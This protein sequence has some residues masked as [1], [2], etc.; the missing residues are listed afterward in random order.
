MVWWG[1]L[2]R[3]VDVGHPGVVDVD[4]GGRGPQHQAAL[5]VQ[6]GHAVGAAAQPGVHGGHV[7]LP[8][9]LLLLALLLGVGGGGGGGG[10]LGVGGDR[11][12]LARRVGPG[13]DVGDALA[14]QLVDVE[15][16]HL[17]ALSR[18]EREREMCT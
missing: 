14:D 9:L 13:G 18:T 10:Q 16:D 5:A 8:L 3:L 2:T 11:E 12:G 4:G 1:G 15:L 7:L 17:L 6:A